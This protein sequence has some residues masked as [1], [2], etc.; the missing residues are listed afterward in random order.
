MKRIPGKFEKKIRK[1]NI[2]T[3]RDLGYFFS[4]L[5]TIY[6][7]SGLAL[8]H[9]TDWN[10]DFIIERKA[11]HI[12][13][14]YKNKTITGE[15]I[16]AFGRLVGESRYRVYDAPTPDQLKIYYEDASL[17]INFST[18][19][20]VYE[21]ITR[22]PLFYHVDVLH[23]NSIQW[24]KWVSDIFAVM[25]IVISVSGLFILKGKKGFSGRGK[26]LFAAGFIPP[27]VAIV[28]GRFV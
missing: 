27:I 24:W 5:I 13:D 12:G 15:S 11:V 20:A 2:A 25:L 8:N 14:G 21:T 10:P 22:R 9:I 3:H 23:R 6:C 19:E 26:W 18:G 28:I 4:G 16:A 17:H 1:W 7:L